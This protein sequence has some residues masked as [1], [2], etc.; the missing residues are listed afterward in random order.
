MITKRFILLTLAFLISYSLY[1][2][3]NSEDS[4]ILKFVQSINRFNRLYMLNL[5]DDNVFSR[6]FPVYYSEDMNDIPDEEDLPKPD[7]TS[8]FRDKMRKPRKKSNKINVS[9][10]P[11]G[12][13]LVQGLT[14]NVAFKIVD[15]NGK[16]IETDSVS[17]SRLEEE[18]RIPVHKGMGQFQYAPTGRKT[19]FEVDIGA[20]PAGVNQITLFNSKG[21]VLAERLFF[22]HQRGKRPFEI[23]A[24]KNGKPLLSRITLDRQFF[25]AI[26]TYSYCET[27]PPPKFSAL[28]SGL[29]DSLSS[30]E[31]V[32]HLSRI[33][34]AVVRKR[35]TVKIR[36][37]R[38]IH[39]QL[40]RYTL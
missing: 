39:H 29:S 31:S 36:K 7:K 23:L 14:G 38:H 6:V 22:V 2:Q 26:K 9:F 18:I 24:D 5:G 27:R 20:M 10:Y 30:L 3:P 16:S 25:P 33:T 17:I 35:N 37:R 19:N 34:V 11:E 28:Y 32:Q 15:E 4:A 12:G 13:Y 1:T 21:E 40:R 8:P